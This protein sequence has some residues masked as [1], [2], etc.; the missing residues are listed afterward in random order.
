MNCCDELLRHNVIDR[1]DHLTNK[2]YVTVFKM[3]VT[4]KTYKKQYFIGGAGISDSIG[5]FFA[6]LFSSNTAKQLV[7]AALHAEKSAAKDIG[8][9]DIDVEMTVAIDAGK[10]QVEKLLRNCSQLNHKR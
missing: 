9:K 8:I 6:R 5:K 7:S 1:I 2:N 3:L 10:K 4:K